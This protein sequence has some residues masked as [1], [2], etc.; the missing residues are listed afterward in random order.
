MAYISRSRSRSVST[1]P[2]TRA[3]ALS[4][5]WRG[6]AIGAVV[7]DADALA[8]AVGAW[9]ATW[10][11]A[12]ENATKST[13][14]TGS[15]YFIFP[16][17][18]PLR[19]ENRELRTEFRIRK[20][21]GERISPPFV[22]QLFLL[23]YGGD[24]VG[25]VGFVRLA[26]VALAAELRRRRRIRVADVVDVRVVRAVDE[27]EGGIVLAAAVVRDRAGCGGSVHRHHVLVVAGGAEHVGLPAG[28]NA[29]GL[30]P[31]SRR[32]SRVPVVIDE[33]R[34]RCSSCHDHFGAVEGE[35][36][37][38]A[39]V[40]KL[41]HRVI[42]GVVAGRCAVI[43]EQGRNVAAAVRG[44]RQKA[45]PLFIRPVDHHVR[46]CVL[47]VV[48][49]QAEQNAA[50]FLGP[51]G[52]GRRQ[53]FRVFPVVAKFDCCA[54]QWAGVLAPQCIAASISSAGVA[55]TERTAVRGVTSSATA[56]VV[57]V[58]TQDVDRGRPVLRH[59]KP[60][61]CEYH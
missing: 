1:A 23:E 24:V 5:T 41:T 46:G 13:V 51:A 25:V 3:T 56:A 27:E 42:V 10:A 59:H 12:A 18:V 49:A 36:A 17:L 39:D 14:Q 28:G 26:K 21:R 54:V 45:D 15:W 33:L 7:L 11:E 34:V 16:R 55:G 29:V 60:C 61:E 4:L 57:I 44:I 47:T 32:Q 43:T 37:A 35:A 19:T 2:F 53:N 8:K 20:K 40:G 50:D 9:E 6:D 52:D 38:G 58:R 22:S 30:R 31:R 48:A